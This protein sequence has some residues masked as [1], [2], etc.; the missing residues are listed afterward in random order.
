MIT[1]GRNHP[2]PH[3]GSAGVDGRGAS[4]A[5][6]AVRSG[7]LRGRERER[8][9]LAEALTRERQRIAADVHDLIMQ[10]LSLAL[11]GARALGDHPDRAQEAA[12]VVEAGERALAAAREMVGG[13][14]DADRKPVLESL[15]SSVRIAARHTPVSFCAERVP[16]ELQPAE[17]TLHTLVHVA[18]EAVANAVKHGRARSIEVRVEYVEEWRLRVHDDGCGFDAEQA[19]GGFG[20]R[21]MR[22]QALALEGSL[23]LTS[24]AGMGTTIEVVLP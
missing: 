3:A 20:L 24:G 6:V 2:R 19:S 17:P 15:E 14:M 11:G 1:T 5:G 9:R 18:R 13:L 21:S 4:D 8:E 10:D 16:A 23:W 12:L 22:Q 7:R